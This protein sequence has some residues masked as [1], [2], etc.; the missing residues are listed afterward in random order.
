[1]RW[2][3]GAPFTA[4]DVI[5]TWHQVMN[6]RNLVVNRG[7]YDEVRGIDRLDGHT[8]AVHLRRP[9]APFVATFFAMANHTYCVLPRHL[10]SGYADLNRVP[11]NSLP[12]GTGPFRMVRYERGVGIHFVANDR[13]WRGAPKLR[14]VYV[15]FVPSANTILA[16]ARRHE[17][18]LDFGASAAPLRAPGASS[19]RPVSLRGVPGMR[20]VLTPFGMVRDIGLNLSVPA[21]RDVRVRRAL[22]YATDRAALVDKVSHGVDLLADSDQPFFSWAYDRGVPRYPHDPRRAA[23]LLD[24]AGWRLG[25]DGLRRRN[26]EPLRITLVGSAGLGGS[27]GA[28]VIV[29]QEW[30]E[31]GIDAAI[32]NYSAAQLY[33]TAEDGGIEQSGKFEAVFE[34][35]VT[36]TDPDDSVIFACWMTPPAGWNIYHLC[37]PRLDAA[38]RAALAKYGRVARALAYRRVQEAVADQVPMIVLAVSRRLDLVSVDLRGYRPARAVTP[39]WNTWE[40]SI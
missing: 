10:L 1:V 17:I 20:V 34:S 29:Q 12:I 40:W 23:A 37:S 24:A 32:K 26:G 5:Y 35:W 13:Y 11:Y 27:S 19:Q 14:E 6:P 38:E 9:F 2:Q 21:L 30:R 15:R 39:F 36:G 4:D 18:D 22:A 7:G 28:Q 16:L 33:G 25:A 31:L 8:I 3:D